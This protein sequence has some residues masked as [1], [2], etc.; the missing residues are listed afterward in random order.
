ML[1]FS[2]GRSAPHW[3]QLSNLLCAVAG[4]VEH[5]AA[6]GANS[7]TRASRELTFWVKVRTQKDSNYKGDK[8]HF[9]GQFPSRTRHSFHW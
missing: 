2:F 9:V 3:V 1:V 7:A 5:L 8:V 6:P 4:Q